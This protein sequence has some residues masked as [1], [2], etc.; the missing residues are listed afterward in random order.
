VATQQTSR[1][2]ASSTVSGMH[3][4][5]TALLVRRKDEQ[6]RGW[7]VLLYFLHAT[8]NDGCDRAMPAMVEPRGRRRGARLQGARRATASV[9]CSTPRASRLDA[10]WLRFS[11]RYTAPRTG[12]GLRQEVR[13]VQCRARARVCVCVCQAAT[14][15]AVHG[16]E[17]S[18]NALPLPVCSVRSAETGDRR[19][20]PGGCGRRRTQTAS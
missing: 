13:V 7:Q 14:L 6:L 15:G 10:G 8:A 12:V 1:P 11:A 17:A 9:C 20:H 18:R 5:C 2:Q 4:C 16:R 19:L 3:A